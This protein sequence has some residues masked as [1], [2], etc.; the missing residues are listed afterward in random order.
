M[1]LSGRGHGNL[2]NLKILMMSLYQKALPDHVK[3]TNLIA[4]DR[5]YLGA[6]VI[7][8]L[9]DCG[10]VVIGTHQRKK[11]FPFTF[12]KE[13]TPSQLEGRRL[14]SES[15]AKSTYWARQKR[16]TERRS[17]T[18]HA[19]AYRMGVGRVATLFTTKPDVNMGRFVYVERRGVLPIS[20][21][22]ATIESFMNDNVTELTGG[23]GAWNGMC[24]GLL[25]GLSQALSRPSSSRFAKM[26]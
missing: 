3:G 6:D 24:S 1:R 22:N 21:R 12:G 14:I 18:V 19:L 5:G 7:A 25:R 9:M 16:R 26:T 17:A 23:Q 4:L 13:L 2:D 11:D 15:G 10:L 20:G 8:Y